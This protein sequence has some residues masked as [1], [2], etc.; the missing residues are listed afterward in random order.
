VDSDATARMRVMHYMQSRGVSVDLYDAALT[1]L[2]P[3]DLGKAAGLNTYVSLRA[4][5]SRLTVYIATELFG[6]PLQANAARNGLTLSN[7]PASQRRPSSY[8]APRQS[9]QPDAGKMP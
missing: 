4:G 2:A 9:S 5:T 8:P 1:A 7:V 3:R 6:T